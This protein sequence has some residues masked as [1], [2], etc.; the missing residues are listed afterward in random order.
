[1]D[2]GVAWAVPT[3]E[4]VLTTALV[5]RF[6]ALSGPVDDATELALWGPPVPVGLAAG[7]IAA[8]NDVSPRPPLAVHGALWTGFDL[9]LL[10]AV[11]QGV[12]R[13]DGSGLRLNGLTLAAALAGLVPGALFGG[14][15]V[16]SNELGLFLGAPPAGFLASVLVSGIV[17]VVSFLAGNDLG[18]GHTGEQVLGWTLFAGT[19]A[20]LTVAAA[21]SL[22]GEAP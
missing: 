4:L 13:P 1:M 15:E 12:G 10:A 8:I 14:L 20:G 22:S 16:E 9:G 3:T 19:T 6:T 21:A 2:A 5:L 11:L 18:A 17:M 7:F